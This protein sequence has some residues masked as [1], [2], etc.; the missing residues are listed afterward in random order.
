MRQSLDLPAAASF[1]RVSPAGTAVGVPLT[2][3]QA[4]LCMV[5]DIIDSLTPLAT[6]YA[7]AI[8][9]DRMS[10]SGDWVAL[11][12]VCDLP[13]AKIISREVKLR[14]AFHFSAFFCFS[15]LCV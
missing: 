14:S 7:R 11:S 9:A 5:D 10:L 3:E 8:K 6:A 12:D 15:G 4:K 1:K 13:T 2:I